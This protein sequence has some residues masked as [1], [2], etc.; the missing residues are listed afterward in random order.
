[1][2]LLE[3][4]YRRFLGLVFIG[5]GV[6]LGSCAFGVWVGGLGGL[7]WFCWGRSDLW[8]LSALEG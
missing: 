7:G 1:M 4:P 6:G 2:G 8:F 3:V 5:F